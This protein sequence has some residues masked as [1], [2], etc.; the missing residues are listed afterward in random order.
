MMSQPPAFDD[1]SAEPVTMDDDA[2]RQPAERPWRQSIYIAVVL[3]FVLWV[4]L[5]VMFQ[6]TYS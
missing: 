2:S 5:M 3:I 4:V 6:R 1:R